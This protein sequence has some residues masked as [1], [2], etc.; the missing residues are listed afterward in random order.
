MNRFSTKLSCLLAASALFIGGCGA[1]GSPDSTQQGAQPTD[2]DGT[3][4]LRVWGA[5]EDAALLAQISSQFQAQYPDTQ[6]DIT[7]EAMPES[8][9]KDQL[10]ADVNNA[11]DVFTFADD[12]LSALAASGVLEPVANADDIISRNSESSVAAASINDKLYAYPL[13]ADN[14]YFMFYN[15][16][17]FTD[18]DLQTLDGMLAVASANGKKITM[19][20]SSGWYLYSFFGNTGLSVGLNEDGISNHCDWNSTSGSIKGTDVAEAM[21]AI[22]NNPGFLNGNDSALVEGAK[23]GSVI[24]GISGVWSATA[25]EEAWGDNYGAVKLPT[26]TCAGQQVQMSSYAGYKMV[27]ANAYSPYAEW[28]SLFADFM[29]NEANQTLRFEQRAQGPAN[30]NAAASGA[31]AESPAIQALI[32][33]SSYASLQRIG[34]AYWSPVADFGATMSSGSTGGQELQDIMDSLVGKITAS[35]T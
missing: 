7:I 15:K 19:D 8:D 22:A 20:W 17:Y 18:A 3:V 23:N 10:L 9:C 12:Q 35:N 32:S 5:E 26:Y 28:A 11:P 21:L 29:S 33:Q 13:T 25:I 1:S 2:M 4:S 34:A 30:K 14:G 24:A 6:F 31:V 16:E 27:G